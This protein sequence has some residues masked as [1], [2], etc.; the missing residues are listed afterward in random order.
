MFVYAADEVKRKLLQGGVE[1][2][3]VVLGVYLSLWTGNKVITAI[4]LLMVLQCVLCLFEVAV[5]IIL[6]LVT[7]FT[8]IGI[9]EHTLTEKQLRKCVFLNGL[10]H[11]DCRGNCVRYW[12][13]PF[14]K[15]CVLEVI[16]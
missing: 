5:V 15:R 6:T 10:K 12:K 2:A 16:K 11:N 1:C 9:K 13:I 8:R 7:C 3:L 14:L 4:V